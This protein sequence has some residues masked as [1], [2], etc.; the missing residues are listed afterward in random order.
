MENESSLI[1]DLFKNPAFTA[2]VSSVL[3]CIVNYYFQRKQLDA[4]WNYDEISKKESRQYNLRVEAYKELLGTLNEFCVTQLIIS[5]FKD[6]S[7]PET[8]I[9]AQSMQFKFN[10]AAAIVQVIANENV[11][12]ILKELRLEIS[13]NP[14]EKTIDAQKVFSL[15]RKLLEA[16]EAD[17]KK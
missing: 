9:K 2:I 16:I 1:I 17:L 13:K 10:K 6:N 14:Y 7:R 11:K 5:E 8:A 15:E 3:T 4:K 12:E